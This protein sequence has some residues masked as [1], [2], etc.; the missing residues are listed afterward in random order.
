MPFKNTRAYLPEC[1]DSIRAQQHS[2]WQLLAVDDG[3]TDSGVTLLQDYAA[4]DSRIKV[5]RNQGKGIIHAL[6]TALAHSN[7][8]Y[9]TRMD[10]DDRMAPDKLGTMFRQ[11]NTA[12]PGHIALGLVRYF[13]ERGIS[14]GY[15]RY[16]EWL[17]RLTRTG[18][19][20]SERYKE[21]V[22]PSPCWMV[23]RRDL[24]T[25]SAFAPDRYPED[26]D[27]AF[28]FFEQGLTCLPSQEV[29][30]HWRDYDA[31]T[32]RN[33][34]HYAQNHFLNLK[35]HYFLKL[36]R[37]YARPLLLWG[38]GKKGKILAKKLILDGLPFVWVCDNPKKIGKQ[39]Y[40]QSLVHYT[41]LDKH[42]QAQSIVTVAN[43]QAQ[44][45]IRSFLSI[46]GHLP[47]HDYYFFC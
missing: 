26:Y 3:S 18:D 28:R 1:L 35:L 14:Q 37:D 32:S 23:H 16:E 6:R 41:A 2:D 5:L 27:L 31:R 34:E 22:I 19:N 30:H 45:Q 20:F 38:A 33:H 44:A 24:D 46:R 10:S 8:H 29:L 21:C 17:N 43:E 7:G 36:D 40:G 4:S 12:G 42:P 11:L 13:S 39:I 25:C 47:M 9:V 15:K